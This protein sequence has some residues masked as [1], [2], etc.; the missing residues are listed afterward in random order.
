MKGTYRN[1]FVV[2]VV[3]ESTMVKE[4]LSSFNVFDRVERSVAIT[5]G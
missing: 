2:G 3:E 4:E 5:I 1:A